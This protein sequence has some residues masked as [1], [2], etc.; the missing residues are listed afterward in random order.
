MK[1]ILSVLAVGV[2]A[3]AALAGCSS[4]GGGSDKVIKVAY[5]K[6]GNF[7]QMDTQMKAVAKQFEAANKG[8]TVKLIPIQAAENDYYTKLSLMNKSA[9]TAPDVSYEDT[10]LIKADAA[11][12]YLAPLDGYVKSWGDWSQFPANA[13][14][15]GQGE[16]GKLYGISMGT[17]TRG[18]W[19][20]KDV[21]KKAGIDV[22]WQPTSWQQ[23]LDA[24]KKIKSAEPDVTPLN[25]YSGKG[26][27]EGSTMQGFEMLLYGTKDTLYDASSKKW[28]AGSKGFTDS[29]DVI[30]QVYQGGLGPTVQNALDPNFGNEVPQL[31]SQGKMGIDLDGS[32]LSSNWIKGGAVPWSDWNSVMGETPMPTQEG[33]SPG[34]TSMSGGWTLALGAKSANKQAAWN[35]IKLAL[36][37]DNSLAYD[38]AATQI[39]V[40]SDVAADSKYVNANPTNKFFSGLVKSTHFRPA[41][42]VYPQVSN[43]IQVAMES[44]M[45]GQQT[46]EQAA[47]VYDQALPGVVGG[48]KNVTTK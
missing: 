20:N 28:I 25:V 38:V 1:R 12:G 35:F 7:T 22:P 44:V 5:Q 40:R 29:L 45:T 14:Q 43:N 36:N 13:K 3:A 8:Y 10:F 15:A 47:K 48:A 11:A 16:D 9:S 24:A 41:T 6:F 46:P 30:K 33:A 37:K 26:A 31:L 18:L 34:S 17:D 21:L 42:T 27:G 19:Y 39:A 4:S 23:V 2:V 32:W